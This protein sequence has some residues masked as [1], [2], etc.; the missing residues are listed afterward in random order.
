MAPQRHE[1]A[2]IEE[3]VGGSQHRPPVHAPELVAT[4]QYVGGRGVDDDLL[5]GQEGQAHVEAVA[6]LHLVVHQ[7][8]PFGVVPRT[9]A[10]ETVSQAQDSAQA[11]KRPLDNDGG[12]VARGIL[13]DGQLGVATCP[14]ARQVV[15]IRQA[16]FQVP[17]RRAVG[18]E[19]VDTLA[20]A[21][22]AGSQ[23]RSRLSSAL[24]QGQA[25]VLL[26]I[27]LHL[28]QAT[29]P[30]V[31]CARVILPAYF[32]LQSRLLQQQAVSTTSP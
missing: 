31:L 23:H 22:A 19:E 6:G 2:D 30:T 17:E 16:V 13:G 24:P 29:A 4:P 10:T 26:V 8:G 21:V 12:I 9:P 3:A 14:T 27:D 15:G 7:T 32:G 5:R 11:G 1:D 20:V 18:Q 25:A 28:G